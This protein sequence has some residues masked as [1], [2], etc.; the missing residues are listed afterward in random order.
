MKMAGAMLIFLGALLGYIRNYLRMITPLKLARALACDLMALKSGVCIS[1]RTLPALLERQLNGGVGARYLWI[2]FKD[3]L[4]ASS[5]GDG[6]T[7]RECWGQTV[8]M[9]PS[10][11]SKMMLPIGAHLGAGGEILGR[12]IDEVREELLTYIRIT[13]EQRGEKLKLSAALCLFGACF[14]V[15]ILL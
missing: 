2:P 13:E 10:P 14:V 7:V 1:R 15:L 5:A 12:A 9:L 11:L 6:M 4:E 8:D 3:A